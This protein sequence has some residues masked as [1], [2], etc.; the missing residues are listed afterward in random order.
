MAKKGGD[1]NS[2]AYKDAL[3]HADSLLKKQKSIEKST[4]T[5][6]AAWDGISSTIFG[7]SGAAWFK[8]V[9]KTTE[10]IEKQMQTLGEMR[11]SLNQMGDELQK[12][13][14]GGLKKHLEKMEKNY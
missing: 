2:K 9:P 5:L 7:I 10:E 11:T 1:I 8:E 14:G 6:N 3:A 4:Q 12:S 13:I